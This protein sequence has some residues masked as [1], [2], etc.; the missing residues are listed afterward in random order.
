QDYIEMYGRPEAVYCDR[1]AALRNRKP[2]LLEIK[3]MTQFQRAMKSLN[4]ELIHAHSPQAKGRVERANRTLQD[5]LVKE[6][7]LKGI[8]SMETANTFLEGFRADYNKRFAKAPKS[9]IDAHRTIEKGTNLG[10]IFSW[11]EERT[12]TKN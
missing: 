12:V 9:Q 10:E 3:G 4:I 11:H 7:S 5:R 2:N 1:H 8:S 6:M